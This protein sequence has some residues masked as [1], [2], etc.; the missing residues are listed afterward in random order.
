MRQNILFGHKYN[1][2]RYKNV[3]KCCSLIRD[4]TLLPYGDKTIVGERGISLSGGQRARI[5]LARAIYKC[6][7]IYLLDDPLSAVDTH[8]GKA[9]FDECI[10]GFLK[11]KLVVLA[12]HQL[13]YLHQAD[14]IVVLYEGV[15]QAKG[16]YQ[17]L[18]KSGIDFAKLLVSE[19]LINKIEEEEVKNA[20]KAKTAE[21]SRLSIDSNLFGGPTAPKTV[22]EIRSEG[23]VSWNVYK[24]YLKAG[25]NWCCV[26]FVFFL[27]IFTQIVA[28]G[29]DYFISEW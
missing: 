7:D 25:G 13:Q 10:V 19:P 14:Q 11:K 20:A 1:K 3:I 22:A 18:Q 26:F 28:S 27:F 8:V 2:D 9:L 17:S 4:F 16:T 29:S 24:G 12:T 6:A 5:N 15:I 21:R 23:A